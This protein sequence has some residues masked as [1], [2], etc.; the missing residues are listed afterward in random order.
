MKSRVFKFK[1][2]FNSVKLRWPKLY[3]GNWA[4]QS[5]TKGILFEAHI[6]FVRQLISRIPKKESNFKVLFNYNFNYIKTKKPLETRMGGGKSSILLEGCNITPGFV[7]IELVNTSDVL[8]Y[9]LFS[10][11]KTKFPFKIRLIRLDE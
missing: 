11:L 10:K 9:Y 8:A 4:F 6:N 3:C 7:F 5:L 1:R 2:G